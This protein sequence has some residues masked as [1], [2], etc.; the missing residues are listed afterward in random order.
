[1]K[2]NYSYDVNLT[3]GCNFIAKIKAEDNEKLLDWLNS[4]PGIKQYTELRSTN[5][6]SPFIRTDTQAS[7]LAKARLAAGMTQQEMAD[8]LGVTTS[9]Y[10]TWEYKKYA[11]KT[12]T[13]LRMSELLDV[14]LEELME[15]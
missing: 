10:Q 11:P 12:T 8:A 5:K 13:L 6:I 7:N 9:Q 14:P 4:A 2:R 15:D 1:M 3:N